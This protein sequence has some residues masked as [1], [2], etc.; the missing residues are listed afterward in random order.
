MN[1]KGHAILELLV[2][3]SIGWTFENIIMFAHSQIF[4]KSIIT[5]VF[6]LIIAAIYFTANFP[7]FR[8]LAE[9]ITK[10]ENA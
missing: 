5:Y 10:D 6:G 7:R 3:I 8:Q 2:L 9:I 1:K 4:G